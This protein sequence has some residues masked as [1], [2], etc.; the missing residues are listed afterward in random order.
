MFFRETYFSLSIKN[1]SAPGVHQSLAK[2]CYS[3][4]TWDGAVRMCDLKQHIIYTFDD[5]ISWHHSFR[6][7]SST[8]K[9]SCNW[10]FTIYHFNQ[11]WYLYQKWFAYR[12]CWFWRLQIPLWWK[13]LDSI[14]FIIFI[15]FDL[16][17]KESCSLT[18]CLLP[19]YGLNIL[20]LCSYLMQ[21]LWIS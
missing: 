18:D 8:R 12:R 11:W 6:I 21:L 15:I 2:H 19:E 17:F 10:F 16:R 14:H 13:N 1:Y 20:S 4:I 3:W 5:W 9:T 7:K